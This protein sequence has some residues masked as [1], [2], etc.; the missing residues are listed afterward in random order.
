MQVD[1]GGGVT[2]NAL[3]AR[4]ARVC[5]RISLPERRFR[6]AVDC[7]VAR[8][9]DVWLPLPVP[10]FR[11]LAPHGQ[12]AQSAGVRVVVPWQG[13]VRIG[14]VA[15][16]VEVGV[17]AALELRE[18]VACLD[19]TPW[20]L[21]PAR[22]MLAAQAARTATPV[23]LALGTMVPVGLDVALE[24]ELRRLPAVDAEAFGAAGEVLASGAWVAA[25][26]FDN[27]LLS[28]WREHGLVEERVRPR[29][30]TERLLCSL[31]PADAELDGRARA[32]QRTALAWLEEHGPSASAA[33]LARAADVPPSAARALV[34]KGYAAYAEVEVPA[35]GP[36]WVVADL[37]APAERVPLVEG[38]AGRTLLHGGRRGQRLGALVAEVGTDVQARQQALVLVPEVSAVAEVA[39]ALAATVPTLALRADH[40]PELRAA[41][42]HEAARGTPLAL[43]GTYP[44]LT[45]ALPRLAHVHVWDAASPSY[46]LLS[47]TRSM[48]CRDA[49]VLA[50]AARARLSWY[51]VLATAEL[52]ARRPERVAALEYPPPRLVTSDLRASSTWPLGSDL[53]RVLRQVAE[54]GR[55]AVVVVPR[56]GYAAGLA[57]RRCGTPVMCPHCDLPLRWHA[58]RERLRCH[59]C[60]HARPAPA[61]CAHCGG[62]ALEPL[63]GA[64]TEWVAR[65]VERVVGQALVW[66]V[67][68]D[69]RPDLTPLLA[70]ESGVVVGTTSVLRLP[71]LPVL[72]LVAFTLGDALYGHEDFRAEEQALRTLLQAAE[73]AGERRPLLLVQTFTPEHPVWATLRSDDVGAAVAAFEE[74][75]SARRARFG[76]PPAAQ[77]VRVQFSHRDRNRA[78][79]AAGA[80]AA[81]L[82]TAGVPSASM[83]G[84]VAT[85]VARVR[86]RYAVHLFV[87]AADEIDLSGWIQ[88]LDRRPGDGVQ[89]RID[90][91][92]YDVGIW[93]E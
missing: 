77:W 18:A 8:A 76:Y 54:R 80:A 49:E 65:E 46:K 28:T 51:D 15:D 90:V 58:R 43:V 72:S 53:I 32:A 2:L 14:V 61:A 56:R 30:R 12:A 88:H 1:T 33:E 60:G 91:D 73:L 85:G 69:H 39:G 38:A 50:E 26:G 57:C 29:P 45:A 75:T 5:H 35:P 13:G 22:R 4:V 41:V 74:T 89:V 16:V 83:L 68:A 10:A 52:R 87:R 71:A 27:E 24:H 6:L 40:P 37:S 23:G 44:S 62:N 20:L 86:D 36:P 92:P 84:P 42:W 3:G 47:G 19:E 93:L 82:R 11:F 55:Q 81:T 34:T 59:Q 66:Q 17:A 63:P 64:G 70:G 31:R 21:A 79:A 7:R 78:H 48:A 25:E 67:D 9:L